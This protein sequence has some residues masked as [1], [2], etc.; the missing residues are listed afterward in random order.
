MQEVTDA[1]ATDHVALGAL[2]A[3]Y[4]D[5]VTRRDWP[6]V[7]ALFAPDAEV[8]LDLG[9]GE[10]RTFGPDELV[11]FVGEAVARFDLFVFTVLNRVVTEVDG[12]EA[13]GRVWL[14]EVR[15]DHDGAATTA[16]GLYED[17]YVRSAAGWRIAGRRYR[18]LARTAPPGTGADL[19]VVHRPT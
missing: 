9:R 17:R 11:G 7:V 6:A 8:S 2:Q 14:A 5:A 4:G 12:D 16:Y 18:S 19:E 15:Q 10:P 3:A 1:N 13:S